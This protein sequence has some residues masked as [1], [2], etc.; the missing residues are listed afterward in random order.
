M[1]RF[2]LFQFILLAGI[3]GIMVVFLPGAAQAQNGQI[4]GN[5]QDSQSGEDLPGA[6]VLIQGTNKGAA[7]DIDGDYLIRSVPPGE[8]VLVVTYVGYQ[9]IEQSV[10]VEAGETLEM[11]FEMT[12]RGVTGEEV[13]IQAQAQGQNQAIN[14]QLSS[15]TIS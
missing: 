6:S 13:V 2:R 7:A 4:R 14:Q 11:N 15:S 1:L 5:I 10:T 9:R 8:H 3:L 12:P